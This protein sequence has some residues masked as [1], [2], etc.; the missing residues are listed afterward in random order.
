M[1]GKRNRKGQ[2]FHLCV[3]CLIIISFA[4][5]AALK[6]MKTCRDAREHINTAN[7]LFD[8]GDYEG[9]LRENQKVISLCD[10]SPPGMRPFSMP[11]SFTRTTA[12]PGGIFRNPPTTLKNCRGA[13]PT[14]PLPG[15]QRFSWGCSMTM[16][17]QSGKSRP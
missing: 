11:G 13:S 3:A 16:K 12:I 2:C 10:D 15:G 9:S 8:R 7:A 6:E 1:G 14:A 4:G 5:C 17:G